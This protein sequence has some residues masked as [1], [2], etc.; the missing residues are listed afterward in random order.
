M[1]TA[2]TTKGRTAKGD[3]APAPV[4]RFLKLLIRPGADG[5][6][7]LSITASGIRSAYWLRPTDGPDGARTFE[8]RK[9]RTGTIYRVQIGP[10]V[11][12][13]CDCPAATHRLTCKHADAVAKLAALGR[14]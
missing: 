13:Q 12:K 6:G 14:I 1:T 7:L 10:G 8:L 11:V 5:P 2:T 4:V 9:F 3:K